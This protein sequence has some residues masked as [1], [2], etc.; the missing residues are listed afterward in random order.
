MFLP[1]EICQQ[2]T[3]LAIM[4][5]VPKNSSGYFPFPIIPGTLIVN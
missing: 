2:L 5:F 4:S 3:N 1:N